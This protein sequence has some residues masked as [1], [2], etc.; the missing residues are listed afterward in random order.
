M[1][2]DGKKLKSAAGGK[3][4]NK[5]YLKKRINKRER[6]PTKKINPRWKIP[7]LLGGAE[8]N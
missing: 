6:K 2:V 3:I 1:N 8:M 5:A 4:R 7:R